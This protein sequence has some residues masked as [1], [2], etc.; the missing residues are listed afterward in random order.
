MAEDKVENYIKKNPERVDKLLNLKDDIDRVSENKFSE[1]CRKFN[2]YF[3]YALKL[4]KD[5]KKAMKKG[6]VECSTS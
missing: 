1:M 5:H 2:T 6:F 4:K 3:E